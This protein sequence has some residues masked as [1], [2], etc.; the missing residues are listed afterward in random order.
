MTR[1]QTRSILLLGLFTLLG[2]LQADPARA[3]VTA[4]SGTSPAAPQT[5]LQ[6]NAGGHALG[7]GA[8]FVVVAGPDRLLRVDF[9][10]GRQVQP[11]AEG[12]TGERTGA[13]LAKPAA[14]TRVTYP[15]VWEGVD[16][17]FQASSKGVFESV[18]HVRNP[19]GGPGAENIRLRY[20]RP[21]SLDARGGLV[22]SFE[23]GN[24]VESAPVAWQEVGGRKRPVQAAFVRHGE[25]EVGFELTG[26]LPGV[27]VTIDPV[28]TW[29]TF[30]GGADY[31]HAVG[32]AV[33][34]S[35]N[36]Y[37][38]GFS[39]AT[40]GTPLQAHGGGCDGFVVK[41]DSNGA[42]LWH[43]FLGGPNTVYVGG[44]DVDSAG[45]VY[46]TGYS[47]ASWGTPVRAVVGGY[48]GFAVKLDSNGTRLWNTFLGGTDSDA[49]FGIA[50]DSNDNV[51]VTGYS[52]VTWG[53]PVQ[54]HTGFFL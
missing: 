19:P 45:N 1:M 7:F 33:D 20:N 28:L 37:V 30:L 2:L 40:W 46:V 54:A 34:G 8:D 24:M 52:K 9:S 39:Y 26:C 25:R 29:N 32:I 35:G 42:R 48:D 50:V 47:D 44:I 6:F 27:P 4:A 12:T 11:V 17:V 36:V 51:Y 16:V 53:T 18:Y 21:V 14:L 41:L 5:L 13:I 49:G 15:E 10:G 3:K 31:D 22:T 43:T 38:A 23:N